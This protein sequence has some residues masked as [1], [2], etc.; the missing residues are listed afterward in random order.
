MSESAPETAEVRELREQ[1]RALSERARELSEA[2]A[3]YADP[4][5]WAEFTSDGNIFDEQDGDPCMAFA[6]GDDAPWQRA[7]WV[8]AGQE[9]AK[10]HAKL[11]PLA[12]QHGNDPDKT[13]HA[14][15]VCMD[16]EKSSDPTPEPCKNKESKK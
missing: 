15:V 11:G 1:N 14:C 10:E 3:F 2:L 9:H 8:L 13:G 7:K 6:K 16:S 5:D 4:K 12:C